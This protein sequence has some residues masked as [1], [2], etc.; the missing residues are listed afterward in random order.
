MNMIRTMW[1]AALAAVVV[2]LAACG[3]GSNTCVDI[4]GGDACSGGGG[5]V[6]GTPQAAELVLVLGA[7]SVTNDGSQSVVA[8]VI[9]VDANRN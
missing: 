4:A 3:G 5:G 7:Q 2:A 8:S 6:G 9:A 1:R